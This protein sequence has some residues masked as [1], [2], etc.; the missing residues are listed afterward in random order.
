MKEKGDIE[1]GT[2]SGNSGNSPLLS[3]I[4]LACFCCLLSTYNELEH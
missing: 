3:T 1:N 2:Q 4:I